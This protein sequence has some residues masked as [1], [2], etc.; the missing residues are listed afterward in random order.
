MNMEWCQAAADP[1]TRP[2]DPG[3]ESA[4]RLPEATPTIAIYYYYSPRKL[5]LILPSHEGWVDLGTAVRVCSP[6]PRLYIVVVFTKDL[7]LPTVGFE[8]WSSHNAVRHVTARPLRH[9]NG[10]CV[11]A[12][13]YGMAQSIPDRS[14]VSELA[15]GFFD[16]YY[17]TS[18]DKALK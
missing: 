9:A 12:A 4:C 18:D 16:G 8:P 6:C 5:I 7:Q 10:F 15:A 14:I 1:Q 3:C 11:Q 2:N 13:I 17:S